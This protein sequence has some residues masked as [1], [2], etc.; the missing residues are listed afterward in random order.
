MNGAARSAVRVAYT[1]DFCRLPSRE[2]GL[3]AR[4]WT[5]NHFL[6]AHG[7]L[8]VAV[9]SVIQ[10]FVIPIPSEVTFGYAG[11]LASEHHL[12]IALVV[13]IGAVG[14]LVGSSLAYF[15]FRWGGRPLVER[16]GRYVLVSPADLDR[17]ERWL[18]GRGEW[19]VAIGR[20]TPLIRMFVSWV[21][22]IS[23]MSYAKFA[24]F[25]FI[26]ALAYAAALAELGYHLA[27]T[28]NHVYRDFKLAGYIIAVVVVL[29]VLAVA[30]HRFVELRRGQLHAA[31]VSRRQ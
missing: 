3:A 15:L 14:E 10:S 5:V 18:D 30:R 6:L 31:R 27:P 26:G 19:A 13:I 25:S 11:V 21:V 8:A 16:Y 1:P 12:A 23:K 7:Y 29:G 20:A 9:L 22:G 2:A 17:A 24:A 4:T 28:W